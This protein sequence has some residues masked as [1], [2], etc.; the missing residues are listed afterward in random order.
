MRKIGDPSV[1]ATGKIHLEGKWVDSLGGS[2][3]RWAVV[4]EEITRYVLWTSVLE[5]IFRKIGGMTHGREATT[6]LTPATAG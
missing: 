1:A 4:Y 3:D 5:Q 2:K 6:A